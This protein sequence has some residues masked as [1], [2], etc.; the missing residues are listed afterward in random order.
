MS[1]DTSKAINYSWMSQAAY[2]DLISV[3]QGSAKSLYD[4]LQIKAL[5]ADKI[6]AAQGVRD[7][8]FS[9]LSR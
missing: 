9:E 1:I 8:W 4:Y 3:I 7:I 2:L 5:N 6:F